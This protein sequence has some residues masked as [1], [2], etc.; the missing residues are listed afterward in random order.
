MGWYRGVTA[1]AA[2]VGP[3]TALQMFANGLLVHAITGGVRPTSESETVVAAMVR[4]RVY[5]CMCSFR[6]RSA[7]GCG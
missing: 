4:P 6:R 3:I 7:S 2:S 1:N 5:V